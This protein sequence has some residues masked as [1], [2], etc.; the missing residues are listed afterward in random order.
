MKKPGVGLAALSAVLVL[1]AGAAA[2]TVNGTIDASDPTQLGRLVPN[3]IASTCAASKASPG[4]LSAGSR[5]YDS[6]MYTNSSGS[7]QCVTVTLTQTSGTTG[8][9]FTAAYLGSF[10]PTNVETNY[11]ADPGVSGSLFSAVTYSFS[12]PAGQLAVIVVHEVNNDIACNYTLSY[13]A[14]TAVT[15]AS[16]RVTATK[17][18]ELLRWRTGTEADLLGFQV[19]RSRGH[20]WKRITRS[21]I[22]AK[23]SVAGASYR[24]LDRSAK[25]GV[26]YRYRIK[27]V[28]RDGTTSWFGPVRVT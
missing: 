16:A 7:P 18:G 5:H 10:N 15:F 14:V 1:A 3:S 25:R 28:N 22:V 17:Q 9:L 13:D 26:A 8:G 12:L 11:L 21:L 19:Y 23:G 6:Y 20:S 2:V 4:H 27:A 24:F